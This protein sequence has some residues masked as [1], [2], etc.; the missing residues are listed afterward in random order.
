MYLPNLQIVLFRKLWERCMR[1]SLVPV[2]HRGDVI[3]QREVS[4]VT[5]RVPAQRLNRDLQVLLEANRVHDVPTIETEAL[6]GFVKSV[7]AND[8]MQP[9]VRCVELLVAPRFLVLKVV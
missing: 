7:R 1:F 8:L 5:I 6:L 3:L 9:G 4:A 2:S